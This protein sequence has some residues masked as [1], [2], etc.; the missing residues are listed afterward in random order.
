ML[1]LQGVG[2]YEQQLAALF[3]PTNDRNLPFISGCSNYLVSSASW[4]AAKSATDAARGDD[5]FDI[6][7][8][9]I[10]VCHLFKEVWDSELVF[11]IPQLLSYDIDDSQCLSSSQAFW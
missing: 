2:G 3:D 6:D 10:I 11:A 4:I 7:K 8:Q 1:L 9:Q 5:V